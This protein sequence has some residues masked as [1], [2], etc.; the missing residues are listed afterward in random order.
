VIVQ[1][2]V[3]QHVIMVLSCWQPCRWQWNVSARAS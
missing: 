2:R 1:N 3:M